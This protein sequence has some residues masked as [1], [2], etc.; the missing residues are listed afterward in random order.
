M[1]TRTTTLLKWIGITCIGISILYAILLTIS[2]RSLTNA[3]AELK[4]DGRPM[5]ADEVTPALIPDN[6][7]AALLYEAA[8]LQ[9]KSEKVGEKDLFSQLGA[10]HSLMYMDSRKPKMIKLMLESYGITSKEEAVS[11][12]RELFQRENTKSALSLIEQGSLKP[13]CRYDLDYSKGPGMEFPHAKNLLATSKLLCSAAYLYAIDGDYDA[14]WRMIIISL[15]VADAQKNEPL[16]I[17][18]LIRITSFS[19]T[20]S[21]IQHLCEKSSPPEAL[22]SELEKLLVNFEDNAPFVSAIDSERLLIGNWVWNKSVLSPKEL[23]ESLQSRGVEESKSLMKLAAMFPPI[24]RADNACYLRIMNE[25]ALKASQI[26][27]EQDPGFQEEL[28]EKIPEYCNLTRSITP[29]LSKFKQSFYGK[30]ARSRIIRVGFALI[31][32]RKNNG[33]FPAELAL[34]NLDNI[35]DPFMGGALHYKATPSGFT[36]YSIGENLT[37][38]GGLDDRRKGDIVWKFEEPVKNQAE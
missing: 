8:A 2:S 1:N 24:T 22:Y 14:A 26:Y 3:Y 17:S 16:L 6:E 23:I 7:N 33:N 5:S 32:Y 28:I 21:V 19:F 12:F 31:R 4:A 9:L 13:G 35:T 27:T 20:A 30:I 18:Q 36:L 10:L 25:L 15:R 34:L 29:S 38:D 37:D 11:Q